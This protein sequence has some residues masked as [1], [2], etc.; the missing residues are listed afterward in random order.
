MADPVS[1][2]DAVNK[3]YVDQQIGLA[4]G[5]GSSTI[6]VKDYGAVGDGVTD[7]T[8]AINAAI[9]AAS[10]SYGTTLHVVKLVVRSF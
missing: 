1:P 5:G 8:A 2:K 10:V 7:D 9:N 6:S 4:G 3:Q